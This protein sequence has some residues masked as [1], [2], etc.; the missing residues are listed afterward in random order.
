MIPAQSGALGH[1]VKEFE[2]L[3]EFFTSGVIIDAIDL[4]FIL[5]FLFII[6]MLGGSVVMPAL[7]AIPL[8]FVVSFLSQKPLTMVA[9]KKLNERMNKSIL[10]V[11]YINGIETIKSI[12][13]QNTFQKR[14]EKAVDF[15]AILQLKSRFISSLTVNFSVLIQQLTTISVVIIGVGQIVEKEMS[16]GALIACTIL[17]SRALSPLTKMATYLSHLQQSLSSFS[18]LN[19]LIEGEV[20]RHVNKSFLKCEGLTGAFEF[21]DV[22]FTYPGNKIATLKNVNFKIKAKEKIGLIGRTGTG[23]STVLKILMGF[24][25]PDSGQILLDGVE[26]GQIDPSAL[27]QQIG[28]LSQEPFLFSG[29]LRDNILLG[30]QSKLNDEDLKSAAHLSGA[31]KLANSHPQGY[32]L[33]IGEQ[34]KGL[35]GGQKQVVA[36]ARTFVHNAPL[37]FLDE[38]TSAMDS[39]AEL[40]CL[41]RLSPYVADKTLLIVSHRIALL[42]IAERLIVLDNGKVVA[43]GDKVSVMKILHNDGGGFA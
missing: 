41:N 27:R 40:E 2:H 35:S 9:K 19:R 36:L 10:L 4:P 23:K 12:N 6:H 32:E 21:V 31:D 37:I 38:P 25:E 34:G 20:E 3:R 24:Y 30:A 26:I 39:Q 33:W 22:T 8:V 42:T 28:Y 11:E 18:S 15:T 16:V 1:A 43:D 13:A 5:L 17:T 14:W 29:T 7:L